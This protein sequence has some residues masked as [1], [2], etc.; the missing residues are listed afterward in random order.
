ML[1][2]AELSVKPRTGIRMWN[3]E[4]KSIQKL[5]ATWGITLIILH[6]NAFLVSVALAFVT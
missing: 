4:A 3:R 5:C 6:M 1:L 2:A